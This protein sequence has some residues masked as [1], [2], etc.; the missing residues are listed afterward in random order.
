MRKQL[1]KTPDTSYPSSKHETIP[2]KKASSLG[3]QTPD[4][5]KGKYAKAPRVRDRV[6]TQL[7]LGEFSV[8]KLVVLRNKIIHELDR[9]IFW[10][11]DE[12]KQQSRREPRAP[13]S[14]MN[15][16]ARR[17]EQRVQAQ[18][19][20]QELQV[21]KTLEFERR[22]QLNESEQFRKKHALSMVNDRYG[23]RY[24]PP[25]SKEEIEKDILD[26]LDV[27][28]EFIAL[29]ILSYALTK[30]HT[31]LVI[32]DVRDTI[33]P[34]CGKAKFEKPTL[35]DVAMLPQH[36]TLVPSQPLLTTAN[37]SKSVEVVLTKSCAIT[38]KQLF[39]CFRSEARII[40]T[41]TK[42]FN[43]TLVLNSFNIEMASQMWNFIHF[44]NGTALMEPKA[45]SDP[46]L[47]HPT[48]HMAHYIF[49]P[50][51]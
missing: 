44:E 16:A 50:L 2:L 13:P 4:Q 41:L 11:T 26:E 18:T 35:C 3:V 17:K 24:V 14:G 32:R 38:A 9:K 40:S 49:G 31:P 23:G 27:H 20:F 42:T 10:P 29:H 19:A 37:Q 43:F 7:R 5:H 30:Q 1:G 28:R 12:R 21:A 48:D 6:T 25:R 15:R 46:N 36:D 51:K 8:N 47:P 34:R 22:K 45:Y 33:S 39:P